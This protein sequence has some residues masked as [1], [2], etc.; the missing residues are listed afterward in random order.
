MDLGS[1][2]AGSGDE[3]TE[4]DFLDAVPRMFI[5]L[6]LLFPWM[7][8]DFILWNMTFP[9]MMMYY[10]IGTREHLKLTGLYVAPEKR[11]AI[12]PVQSDGMSHDA[13]YD[14]YHNL[15]YDESSFQDLM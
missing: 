9:E 8:R 7:N 1:T 2:D 11:D 4:T 6:G 13:L 10:V 3:E 5:T 15:Q 14:Y 12:I